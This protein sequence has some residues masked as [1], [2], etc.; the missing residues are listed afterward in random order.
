MSKLDRLAQKWQQCWQNEIVDRHQLDRLFQLFVAAYTQ[1][2]RH[3][4]NL[5][6]IDRVLATLD[7]FSATLEN[8]IAVILAAWFHDFVYDPRAA[9]NELQSAKSARE[10]LIN[11]VKSEL[12]LDRVQALILATQGH[13]VDPTD[14]DRSIFLD[15]DLAILGTDPARYQIYCRA[16][17]REY[18]W[19]PD[20]AYQTGRIKVL[21]SFLQRDRLYHTDLLFNE[22]ESIARTNLNNEIRSM[23]L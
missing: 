14:R 12:L 16:I 6:H 22:L 18:S 11:I 10:L 9:D 17:R 3:Y 2:D 5:T 19:V 21:Q 7:R 20:S 8:P 4:H 13:Q 1:P 15:A 23:N